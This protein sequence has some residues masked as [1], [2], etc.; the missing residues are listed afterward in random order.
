MRAVFVLILSR[1][2][3]T[4]PMETQS[5][6]PPGRTPGIPPQNPPGLGQV[7]GTIPAPRDQDELGGAESEA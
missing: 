6:R 2:G 5:E 3:W 4:K 1:V 7:G